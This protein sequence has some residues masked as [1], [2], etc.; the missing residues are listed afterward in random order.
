METRYTKIHTAGTNAA[1]KVTPGHFA[2]NHSHIN[3]YLDMTTLKTRTSEAQDV[4]KGMMGTYLYGRYHCLY[5]GNRGDRRLFVGGPD[6]KRRPLQEYAQDHLY[7]T[8]G[9]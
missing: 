2:T 1:L 5:G 6:P 7:C 3:Y 9:V 4:A 8:S